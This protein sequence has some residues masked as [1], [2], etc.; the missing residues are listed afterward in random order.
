MFTFFNNASPFKREEAYRYLH[1]H[2]EAPKDYDSHGRVYCRGIQ[3]RKS[4]D[5]KVVLIRQAKLCDIGLLE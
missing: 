4:K 1:K 3:A 5:N 2:C